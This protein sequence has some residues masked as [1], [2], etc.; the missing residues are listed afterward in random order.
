[1]C[2]AGNRRMPGVGEY[3]N[4]VGRGREGLT[5]VSG[6]PMMVANGPSKRCCPKSPQTLGPWQPRVT[7]ISHFPV[8]CWVLPGCGQLMRR[9]DWTD[10]YSRLPR[11]VC[12]SPVCLYSL[13]D[14]LTPPVKTR[15]LA[16][17]LMTS[18]SSLDGTPCPS[19]L[20]SLPGPAH[21]KDT[22]PTPCRWTHGERPG[23]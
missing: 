12:L 6:G 9:A 19:G 15:A 16:L 17:F 1:M 5:R 8:K 13:L 11:S 4:G 20:H 10:G 7:N 2:Q 3:G 23:G 22:Q 21:R 14:S 18:S